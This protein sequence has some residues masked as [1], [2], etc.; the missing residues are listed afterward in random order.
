MSAAERL[1]KTGE[2]YEHYKSDDYTGVKTGIA[3]I[4]S[5][6]GTIILERG[7]SWSNI[8]GNDV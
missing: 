4:D 6:H 2:L 5:L 8:I 7:D 3:V 1:N